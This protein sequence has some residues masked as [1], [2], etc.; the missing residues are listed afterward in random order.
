M[1]A[2]A[3]HVEPAAAG[4]AGLPGHYRDLFSGTKKRCHQGCLKRY[5]SIVFVVHVG[6]CWLY[7]SRGGLR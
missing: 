4:H 7:C 6:R 5:P 3:D 1:M 2:V